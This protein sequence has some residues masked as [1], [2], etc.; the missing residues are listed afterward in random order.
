V[1]TL[2]IDDLRDLKADVIAR[3]FHEGLLQLKSKALKQLRETLSDDNKI[4]MCDYIITH[5]EK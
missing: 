3:N 5:L 2:L 4:E 1:R